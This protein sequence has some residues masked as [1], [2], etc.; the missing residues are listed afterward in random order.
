[1][2]KINIENKL[3]LPVRGSVS[4]SIWEDVI[5]SQFNQ[6]LKVLNCTL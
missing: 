5:I 1:M 4:I 2:R 6:I 3:R